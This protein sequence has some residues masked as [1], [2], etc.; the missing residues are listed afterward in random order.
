MFNHLPVFLIS[1]PQYGRGGVSSLRLVRPACP[2]FRVAMDPVYVN[3]NMIPRVN[4]VKGY[5]DDNATYGQGVSWLA[6]AAFA[7]TS[8]CSAGFQVLGHDCIAAW[9]VSA[10]E[11]PITT[12]G[13]SLSRA[14][15]AVGMCLAPSPPFVPDFCSVPPLCFNL[16]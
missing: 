12:G 7:F 1:R 13:P 15:K 5:M 6:Q 10:A 8:A 4:S 2:F 14:I 3:L 11:T 9:W 16:D